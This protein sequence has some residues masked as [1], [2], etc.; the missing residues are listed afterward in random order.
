[1]VE[2]LV[3][4]GADI[5]R[6]DNEGWTPL[7]ATASCGY[8]SQTHTNTHTH[9]HSGPTIPFKI[10]KYRNMCQTFVVLLLFFS[11]SFRLSILRLKQTNKR[12][13]RK[14][15]TTNVSPIPSYV[16]AK[17]QNFKR[18]T[19]NCIIMNYF[20]IRCVCNIAINA[21]PYSGHYGINGVQK[22]YIGQFVN[23]PLYFHKLD[24]QNPF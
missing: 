13:T 16:T 5:N 15:T 2:F 19:K 6:Q 9:T 3:E 24:R 10:H 1:M 11:S 22:R 23:F 20:T 17:V 21:I 14:T 18:K 8:V 12:I 7:H 4:Q